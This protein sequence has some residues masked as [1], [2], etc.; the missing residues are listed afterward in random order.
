VAHKENT[1][2]CLA[3]IFGVFVVVLLWAGMSLGESVLIAVGMAFIYGLPLL[4]VLF[5][6]SF[7]CNLFNGKP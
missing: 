2:G 7:I 4:V 1:M 3:W 6:L 5:V